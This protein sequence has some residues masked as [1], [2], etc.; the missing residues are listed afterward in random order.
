[1]RIESS[2]LDI[3]PPPDINWHRDVF[4]N[5]VALVTFRERSTLLS[6]ASEVVIQHYEET[7]LDFV[8]ESYAEAYP[9]LYDAD[10]RIELAAY[11]QAVYPNDRRN[12]AAWL[13][14]LGCQGCGIETFVLVDRINRGI[15]SPYFTYVVREEQGVQSPACTLE[16]RMGSCRDYAALFVEACRVLGLASRFVSGYLHAPST[17]AGN[18]ATHAWSEVYLPGPGWKGFDSTTGEVTGTR[19]IPIAVAR[20]PESVPPVAGSFIGPSQWPALTVDVQVTALSSDTRSGSPLHC[21]D[22]FTSHG[23]S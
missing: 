20:H 1:V 23:A 7:P 15:A 21:K 13:D 5:S 10:E 6:I 18:G 12:I 11:Q 2:R 19:H 22:R 4:D 9:F 3:S 8:V 14:S 17:E 16:T